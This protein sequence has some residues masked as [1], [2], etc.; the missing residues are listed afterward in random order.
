MML[1]RSIN[2]VFFLSIVYVDIYSLLILRAVEGHCLDPKARE[3]QFVPKETKE[4]RPLLGLICDIRLR[5][6]PHLHAPLDGS[7]DILMSFLLYRDIR[8]L[9]LPVQVINVY[10]ELLK[11][12]ELRNPEKFLKCHF[13]NTFFYNKVWLY[14]QRVRRLLA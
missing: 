10:M 6:D 13:F 1:N 2:H 9:T 5:Q 3:L 7:E 8:S 12:R 11:E 14:S 4:S